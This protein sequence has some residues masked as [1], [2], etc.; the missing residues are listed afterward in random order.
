MSPRGRRR[1]LRE[2]VLGNGDGTRVR[3]RMRTRIALAVLIVG[4]IATAVVALVLLLSGERRFDDYLTQVRHAR[5]AQ[6]ARTLTGTYHAPQGW[7]ASSVYAVGRVAA[8]SNVDVAVYDPQGR[9]LF[10]VQGYSA[11]AAP[12]GRPTPEAT[13][14]TAPSAAP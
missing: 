12:G 7:D 3:R 14:S 11:G 5:S 1:R 4:L 8:A 13:P 2:V 6:V 9:L 10:T